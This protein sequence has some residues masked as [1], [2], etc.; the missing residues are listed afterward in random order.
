MKY[1]KE[2]ECRIC[3]G[4]DLELILD[5]GNQPLANAFIKKEDLEKS[6]NRFPL[7]LYLCRNC[8]LLQLLDIVDKEYLFKEY[9]YLTSASK[10]IVDHFKTYASEI[11]DEFLKV[12]DE[13]LVIEIGS[14]D[15]S[16]LKEF[17]KF[18]TN[19]L[20]I[21]PAKNI[22]KI[23]NDVGVP[24]KNI[25]LSFD[26]AKKISSEQRA[27]V[28]I[29][30]NVLGHIEDLK[31][32][33]K[34]IRVLL[35]DNG[36]FVF[37]IPHLLDLMQKLEFDTVYHEHLS[38]F[39]L[40]PLIS[41]MNEFDLE[42]FDVKKQKVHGGTIRAFV[43]KKGQSKIT[44]DLEKLINIEEKFGIYKIETYKIFSQNV[45]QIKN[46]LQNE[47]KK[48]KSEGKTIFGYGAP[49]KG[50]VLLN[51]CGIGKEF[52]EYILDTTPLKQGL[53]TPGMH[54]PVRLYETLP[55]NA[56]QYVA[57]LLAWN[58]EKDII[59]KE[60]EFRENGGKFLVPIP[61]PNIIGI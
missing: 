9:L 22:A 13:P 16:L 58:Y 14:N 23:A 38:Y 18:G 43:S 50:N 8:H 59:L 4:Q 7:R 48:I 28:I 3:S 6:E 15:G 55:K 41:L 56:S 40:K 12:L 32:F 20:G 46:L 11:Y 29:A 26:A 45:K 51:Y 49:A 53:Y 52:L 2:T 57:L 61:T 31:E 39:S 30:N 25:F 24:T 60:N 35:D 42:L 1:H 27:S 36:I 47:L 37:E 33:I 10:P 5:L 21:E 54:I 17:Q 34:C 44:P 19:V